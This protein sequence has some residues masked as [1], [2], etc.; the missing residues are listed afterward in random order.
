MP[1]QLDF[2]S[3]EENLQKNDYLNY[4]NQHGCLRLY[5]SREIAFSPEQ[6]TSQF[7]ELLSHFNFNSKTRQEYDDL[8][9]RLTD[10]EPWYSLKGNEFCFREENEIK[11]LFKK[12]SAEEAKDLVVLDLFL[13]YLTD[14]FISWV[15]VYNEGCETL[16]ESQTIVR[17]V[18]VQAY[19]T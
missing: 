5:S 6:G 15:N 12:M 4:I 9:V 2:S 10:F 11:Y 18:K 17:I 8:S 7:L 19:E 16:P 14:S 3:S 13:K 1:Q